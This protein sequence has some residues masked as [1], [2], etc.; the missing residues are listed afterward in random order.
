MQQRANVS[1]SQ[2]FFRVW[3]SLRA[4]TDAARRECGFETDVYIGSYD[5][6]V[7]SLPNGYRERIEQLATAVLWLNM[8]R[9]AT[10]WSMTQGGTGRINAYAQFILAAELLHMFAEVASARAARYDLVLMTR[11][12]FFYDA[13]DTWTALASRYDPER[14][15]IAWSD[16][17]PQAHFGHNWDGLHVFPHEDAAAFAYFFLHHTQHVSAIEV[18]PCRSKRKSQWFIHP[19]GQPDKCNTPLGNLT[20]GEAADRV[21]DAD[22]NRS[23]TGPHRQSKMCHFP[24]IEMAMIRRSL[25]RRCPRL[26]VNGTTR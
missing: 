4:L 11:D 22:E 25:K 9:K 24:A 12:D 17:P 3:P 7:R 15:N 20:R 10:R 14:L 21:R 18:L 16:K 23:G 26:E 19:Y 13:N 5:E 1:F 8:S 2:D 6:G